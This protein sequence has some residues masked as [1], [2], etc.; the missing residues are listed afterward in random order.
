VLE[1]ARLLVAGKFRC[2]TWNGGMVERWNLWTV[3]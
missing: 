2:L 1:I 3:P